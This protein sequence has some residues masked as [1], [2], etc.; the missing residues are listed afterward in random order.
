MTM[1]GDRPYVQFNFLIDLGTGQD[2]GPH[3]GF[4]ECSSVE[5]IKGLNKSAD[6]TLKRGV[7]GASDLHDWLN[8]IRKGD[9]EADRTVTI[10]MQ[11]EEHQIVQT[12]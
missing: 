4:Q 1:P 9:K 11:D 12:R 8:Q 2:D 7:I 5:K 10:M 3:A 6:V